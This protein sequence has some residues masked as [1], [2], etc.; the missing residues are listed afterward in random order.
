MAGS[1]GGFLLSGTI[2]ERFSPGVM[3][4][5]ADRGAVITLAPAYK[6]VVLK[7]RTV[8]PLGAG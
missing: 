4:A 6:G 5:S 2:P 3:A 1:L 8:I 7:R